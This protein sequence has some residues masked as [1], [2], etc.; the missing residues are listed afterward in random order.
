MGYY[1][2][3]LNRPYDF[4]V[5]IEAYIY[6]YR[7]DFVHSDFAT[8]Y[9]SLLEALQRLFGIRL[10]RDGLSFDQR[11]LWSLFQST[12]ESLGQVSRGE[13]AL[14]ET[15]GEWRVWQGCRSGPCGDLGGE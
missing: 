7:K 12:V 9:A 5:L 15:G 13:F 2:A 10:I 11:V 14:Q 1:V 8:Y 6:T 3:R 4:R